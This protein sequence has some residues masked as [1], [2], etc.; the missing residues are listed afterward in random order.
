VKER[1][2]YGNGT[3]ASSGNDGS[4]KRKRRV[5]GGMRL[6]HAVTEEVGCRDVVK[7]IEKS[8]W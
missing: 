2:S 6:T 7:H 5:R 3:H 1:G 8:D 4:R